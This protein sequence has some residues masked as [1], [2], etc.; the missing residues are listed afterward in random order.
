MKFGKT[1]DASNVGFS[2]QVCFLP[3]V[4]LS[5]CLS[6]SF[7]AQSWSFL[8]FPTLLKLLKKNGK[9]VYDLGLPI[10]PPWPRSLE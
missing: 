4:C 10:P 9:L 2:L 7:L 5:V 1:L 6:L 8:L 3:Q